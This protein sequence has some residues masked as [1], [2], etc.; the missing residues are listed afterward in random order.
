MGEVAVDGL[1]TLA[2]VRRIEVGEDAALVGVA[3]RSSD[4]G[5]LN[6]LPASWREVLEETRFKKKLVGRLSV[7]GGLWAAVMLVLFGVPVVYGFMAD[8]QKALSR[9]HSRQYRA[10][11]EVRSKV[12]V[13]KKY[14][15]HSRGALEIMK[16][17]SDRLP[18]G[19]TLTSWN[20][21]RDESLKVDGNAEA[22]KPVYDF[23][24]DMAAMAG[25]DGG[26]PVFPEVNLAGPKMGRDG[27]QTFSLDCRY[28]AED[29]Q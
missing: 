23:K 21:K 12:N 22:P 25:E 17:V 28:T 5:V 16:A 14:S 9:E 26:D 20:Y 7:A 11:N 15:D 6:A 18:E 13:V 24:D 27:K 10:V 1:E 3:E 29:E 2:P 4:A 19:M 8:H